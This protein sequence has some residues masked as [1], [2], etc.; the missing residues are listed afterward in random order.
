MSHVPTVILSRTAAALAGLGKRVEVPNRLGSVTLIKPLGE[1]GMSVVHLGRHELL[2]T[3]VAVKFLLDI[4]ASEEDPR[5]TAFLEGAK[6]AAA[7]KHPGLNVIHHAD[8]VEGIP[9]LVMELIEGPTLADLLREHGPMPLNI[10]RA[11]VE[12]VCAAVGELHD[13]G[14][15]H[16]DIKPANIMIDPTGRVVVTDFGLAMQRPAALFGGSAGCVTGTPTYMA[17]EMFEANV[18]TRTDVYAIGVTMFELLTGK[19]PFIGDFQELRF[20]HRATPLPVQPL[21][22]RGAPEALIVLIERAM[23]KES[24]Y[25]PKSARHVLDAFVKACDAAGIHRASETQLQRY[26]EIGRGGQPGAPQS[27]TPTPAYYDRLNTLAS[28]KR[29]TPEG[30]LAAAPS[31]P[32]NITSQSPSLVADLLP[33]RAPA[34]SAAPAP[35]GQAQ[36]PSPVSP[37]ANAL[38]PALA[39]PVFSV[40][41]GVIAVAAYD[42][43]YWLGIPLALVLVGVVLFLAWGGFVRLVLSRPLRDGVTRCG[44]CGCPVSNLRDLR[45]TECGRLLGAGPARGEVPPSRS[46]LARLRTFGA[47]FGVFLAVAALWGPLCAKWLKIE[48]DDYSPSGFLSLLAVAVPATLASMVALHFVAGPVA[49]LTG[50]TCCGKCGASLVGASTP[51]CPA[52]HSRI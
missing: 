33:S 3:N 6:A 28:V 36:S 12:S 21:A 1:G 35:P 26:L 51:E 37:A 41:A 7:I 22:E 32:A 24:L 49:R 38:P 45:C 30:T 44:W 43:G 19:P 2:Q 52:C 17:P 50:R 20:A 5:F 10:A 9:Y 16:R 18:S 46:F 31:T 29:R 40:L 27:A 11:V 25:R 47:A 48:P 39:I 13:H 8:A 14:I 42:T 4:P 34:E 15:I 23:H